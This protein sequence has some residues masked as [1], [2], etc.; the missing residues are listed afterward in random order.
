MRKNICRVNVFLN[1]ALRKYI[2]RKY[3]LNEFLEIYFEDKIYFKGV[4]YFKGGFWD[5]LNEMS[6]NIFL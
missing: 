2:L 6:L 4:D 3:I 5:E 1:E